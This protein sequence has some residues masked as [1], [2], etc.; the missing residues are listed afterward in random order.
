MR[1]SQLFWALFGWAAFRAAIVVARVLDSA[2]LLR[3]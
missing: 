3:S 1:M 2:G